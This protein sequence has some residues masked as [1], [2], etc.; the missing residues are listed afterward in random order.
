MNPAAS[1]TSPAEQYSRAIALYRSTNPS[2]WYIPGR[3]DWPEEDRFQLQFHKS[4]HTIRAMFPGNGAGKTTVAATEADWFCQHTHPFQPTPSE[5]VTVIWICMTYKQLAMMRKK[6]EKCF[7]R[8]WSWNGQ[9]QSYRWGNGSEI[10]VVSNDSDW[11]SVQGFEA[12][13]IIIDEE[14]GQDIWR[15]L[16]MR[17]RVVKTR[18]I[19]SATAT[20]GKNWMY[21][22]VYVPWLKHHQDAGL[23]EDQAMREQ[24]DKTR[25]VWARGGIEDN[26]ATDADDVEWHEH[27][28]QYASPQEKLVRTQGGFV[29]LNASPVFD[30]DALAE[31]EV[32]RNAENRAGLHP[33]INGA[34]IKVT[35]LKVRKHGAALHEYAFMAG[36]EPAPGGRIT[37]YQPPAEAG[38]D[39]HYVVG[40]DFAYGLATGDFDCAFVLRRGVDDRVYQVAEAEGHWGPQAFAVVLFALGWYY[41]EALIVGEANA[42]G[43]DVLRRLFDELGYTY[44]YCRD[45]DQKKHARK[46]DSLGYYKFH[47]SRVIPRLQWAVAP[48][49]QA[50][51][52][53]LPPRL[54]VRSEQT[55]DQLRRYQ[56]RPKLAGAEIADTPDAKLTMG[57]ESGTHDDLVSAAAGAVT[58]WFELPKFVRAEK[59]VKPGSAADVL[60]HAAVWKPEKQ[61]GAYKFARSGK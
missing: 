25:W 11:K 1:P 7:T 55:L 16:Q 50:T 40:A 60:G 34:L 24:T 22:D 19:V 20:A 46:S 15:E 38:F 48:V 36:E 54:M 17:R 45:F 6:L 39:D 53:R 37:V 32:W 9:T 5:P 13:L 27:E 10:F 52:K 61:Q 3:Q 31:I 33:A 59:P 14:C 42:I 49:D 12:H 18:F 35:D 28:V 44:L 29:D 56:R 2:A 8:G 47:G 30:Q 41:N 57:A 58:G 26:P 23:T 21:H 51:G 4:R 43:L